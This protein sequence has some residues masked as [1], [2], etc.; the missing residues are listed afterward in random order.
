M[1]TIKKPEEIEILKEGGQRLARILKAVSEKV[2]PGV[3]TKELN[4]YAEQLIAEGGDIG[5]FLNYTPHGAKRPYPASLCVSINEEIVHGIPNENDRV[6]EE[7][8]IVSIDLGLT[9][10]NLITDH[11]VSVPVGNISKEARQLL[12]VTKQALTVGIQAVKPG[13]YVGDIGAAIKKYVEP[14]GFG[15]IEML[16]GHG[17]GYSVHEDP[18]VPNTAKRGQG[19]KLKPGMV[20]ALEP[21]LTLGGTD[22][23][24]GKDGY[25]YRT[26]DRSLAAHFE[27]TIV[28]TDKG[29][30]I[31]TKI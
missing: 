25:T 30:E 21:M 12:D 9:H 27:H 11:A 5:A 22:I 7:G 2:V 23:V 18:F 6:L 24:L 28:I 31:L 4:E 19:P 13:G 17:V 14:F 29:A 8:D 16:S 20:L 10:K 15:I 1:I 26:K 3:S